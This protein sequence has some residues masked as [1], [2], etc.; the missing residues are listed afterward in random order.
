MR[1]AAVLVLAGVVVLLAPAPARAGELA[2]TGSPDRVQRLDMSVGGQPAYGSFATPA[3]AP[4]V[5]AMYGHGFSFNVDGPAAAPAAHRTDPRGPHGR[6]ELPRAADLPPGPGYPYERSRGWPVRSGA[7]DLVAAAQLALERCPS[8]RHVVLLGISM[9]AN[10]SGIATSLAAKRAD[11]SP[12]FDYWIGVE[13]VYN[14]TELYQGAR[15]V[16][17]A[18]EFAANAK[19]DIEAETGGTPETAPQAY[20]DRTVV[21][22]APAIARSGLKGVVLVHGREDGLARST[23]PRSCCSACAPTG[24]R[25]TSTPSARAVRTT[26][27]TRRSAG[28]RASRRAARAR[29]RGLGEPHRHRHR[30]RPVA[31]LIARGEPLRATGTSTSTACGRRRRCRTRQPPAAC[32]RT[33]PLGAGGRRGRPAATRRTGARRP[34]RQP[35]AL[36]RHR[37]AR[38]ARPAALLTVSV[39]GGRR[40]PSRS[41]RAGAG[42]PPRPAARH[43]PRPGSRGARGRAGGS[44][45][46]A[47]TGTCVPRRS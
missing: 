35:P 33:A 47:A 31:A 19:A 13:G 2:C 10:A 6:D 43:R 9:G 21:A 27:P 39:D 28:T 20:L 22:L 29:P 11:G 23:R 36:P 12:L 15:A 30:L 16:A 5:L 41:P 3:A 38:P 45:T 7:E 32:P 1:R 37:S 42:R 25:P 14:L 44:S 40:V 18:N 17:P 8:I 24:C 46:S 26:T 4:K 34:L